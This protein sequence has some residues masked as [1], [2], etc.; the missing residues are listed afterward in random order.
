[1][2]RLQVLSLVLKLSKMYLGGGLS[3]PLLLT[4]RKL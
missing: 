2:V 4:L 3:G 1:M